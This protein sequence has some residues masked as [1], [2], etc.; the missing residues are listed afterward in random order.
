MASTPST[1][2]V[3]LINKHTISIDSYFET[4][5]NGTVEVVLGYSDRMNEIHQTA[6]P[7]IIKAA[8]LCVKADIYNELHIALD[9]GVLY[10]GR[11]ISSIKDTV[12]EFRDAG[13]MY[14]EQMKLVVGKVLF[15]NEEDT[16]DDW[17][18]CMLPSMN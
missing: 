10:Y 1:T 8:L 14:D 2:K 11:E 15:M 7:E 16:M 4:Y 12:D 18:T 3:G 13:E 5:S 9:K 6:Y 17:V